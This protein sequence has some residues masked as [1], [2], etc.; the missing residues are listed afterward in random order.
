[1]DKFLDVK[2]EDIGITIIQ[3]NIKNE[4][5]KEGLIREYRLNH[6]KSQVLEFQFYTDGSL[7]NTPDQ[8]KK[9]GA[10]WLQTK[11][12]NPGNF[13]LASITDW[14][15][16]CKA[17]LVAIILAIVT[18]PQS[19]KV[20]IVTD[21]ASCIDTYNRLSKPNPRHTTRRWIKKKNWSL[22]M[23]LLE[24]KRRKKIHISFKKVKAHSGE[25]ENEK[26]DKLAKEGKNTTEITWKDPRRPI[27]FA[28]PVWNQ[29]MIE[30]VH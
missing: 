4:E 7:G 6:Q 10:A 22:W 2:I 23:R 3:D 8:E 18:V 27:W 5:H 29:L 24:I 17:E 15:S 13:Y 26:V 16:S 20:E 30:R 9:M 11:G 12:P 19:S 21:S 14:P 25:P 28:L 1:V